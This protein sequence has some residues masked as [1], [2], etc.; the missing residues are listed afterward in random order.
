MKRNSGTETAV[1]VLY[2]IGVALL[3]VQLA[4]LASNA[5][6]GVLVFGGFMALHIAFNLALADQL[7]NVFWLAWGG[8]FAI[9]YGGM[10]AEYAGRWI[11][12]IPWAL[13][14]I[15]YVSIAGSVIE[16]SK[17]L[18]YATLILGAWSL[19]WAVIGPLA[20]YGKDQEETQEWTLDLLKR[21]WWI[22]I[23]IIGGVLAIALLALAWSWIS[24]WSRA[25]RRRRRVAQRAKSRPAPQPSSKRQT[26]S[27]I[28][29]QAKSKPPQR[30]PAAKPSH[31]APVVR[32][33]QHQ[34]IEP[35]IIG[36]AGP[37]TKKPE[38]GSSQPRKKPPIN[39]GSET[40]LAP[41]DTEAE[42][43]MYAGPRYA[44]ELLYMVPAPVID[45]LERNGDHFI[46]T[47]DG[48]LTR[49]HGASLNRVTGVSLERP[50]GLAAGGGV[51]VAA[52]RD[53]RFVALEYENGESPHVSTHRVDYTI[54]AFAVNPFGTIV[55]YAPAQKHSVFAV[56][57]ASGQT[58][59][60]SEDVGG[61][62]AMAFSA[63]GRLL[64]LGGRDGFVRL[65]DMSMRAVVK[66][67]RPPAAKD[68]KVVALAD[69]PERGWVAGYADGRVVHWDASGNADSV[70][71]ESYNVAALVVAA[72][73]GR[74]AVGCDDGHV[75]VHS[76]GSEVALFDDVVSADRVVGVAFADGG[77]TVIA[78]SH[79]GSV[80]RA[81]V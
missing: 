27:T 42:A 25:K 44:G 37:A 66:T 56:L 13:A 26:G 31:S 23:A 43:T 57:L 1:S 59:M 3:C 32:T 7:G 14:G 15:L 35:V 45:L 5:W 11:W 8:A 75:V 53:K 71:R 24:D 52:D 80:K 20:L 78:A 77:A 64:A 2:L 69:C 55:A 17:W 9:S 33:R 54:G 18:A 62:S 67:L 65:F 50:T 6:V 46:L 61:T 30:H 40:I 4:R 76:I 10:T 74:M 28:G 16:K 29:P 81:D 21:W 79:D 47:E 48:I 12:A 60:L 72:H 36:K 22:P 39:V 41:Q 34:P 19:G 38:I 68:G 73:T 49:W 51:I 63:D 70:V 58:Q